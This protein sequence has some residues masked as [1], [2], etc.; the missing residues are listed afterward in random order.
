MRKD[1]KILSL[2]EENQEMKEEIESVNENQNKAKK[3]IKV[4]DK[5]MHDVKKEN[6]KVKQDFEKLNAEYKEFH[7]K[8]NR[9]KK[10]EVRKLKKQANRDF[11]SDLK[12]E[13]N[14]SE[15][16]CDMCSENFPDLKSLKA[17][18]RYRHM[19]SIS[20]QTDEKFFENKQ[21]QTPCS[22]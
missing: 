20:T 3:E 16:Y 12:T 4:K 7:S 11:L 5:E 8:V 15:F 18:V 14:Q 1:A 13:A 19:I 2:K 21:S 6:A 9:E 17:H 22:L 10:K